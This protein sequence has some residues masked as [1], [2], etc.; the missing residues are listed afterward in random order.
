MPHAPHSYVF[1]PGEA[2]PVTLAVCDL[3]LC[4]GDQ[5]ERWRKAG[6]PVVNVQ[7]TREF[8]FSDYEV[9]TCHWVGWQLAT[10]EGRTKAADFLYELMR[11]P[12][13]YR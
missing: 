9:F 3:G 2:P 7:G 8:G 1:V 13:P 6:L 5:T 4:K 11:Q 10:F 12:N